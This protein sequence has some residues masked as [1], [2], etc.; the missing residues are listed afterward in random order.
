MNQS[1]IN[2]QGDRVVVLPL[3]IENK[4]ASGIILSTD[5]QKEREEM[6]NTTGEVIS[7]GE[8]CTN[9][10]NTKYVKEGDRIVFA[11]YSGLLYLG[12]DGKKYRVLGAD[13]V[14]ATLDSDVRLVDPYL[15]KGNV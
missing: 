3:E 5:G 2:P 10:P 8:D 4:T 15:S 13:N 11:K 1:G 14:V 7:V 6:A 12:K 9:H